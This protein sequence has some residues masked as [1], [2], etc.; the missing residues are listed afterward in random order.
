MYAQEDVKHRRVFST[1]S[2]RTN[3]QHAVG[4]HAVAG[5]EPSSQ[6]LLT[7]AKNAF[8]LDA[9]FHLLGQFLKLNEL[10]IDQM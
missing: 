10:R 1:L 2:L 9:T 6:V 5:I 7:N 3:E 4:L 8:G